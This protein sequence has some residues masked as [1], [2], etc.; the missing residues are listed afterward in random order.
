M[1]EIYNKIITI[2]DDNTDSVLVDIKEKLENQLLVI[3]W[4]EKYG[5]NLNKDTVIKDRDFIRLSDDHYL[6]YFKE[7]REEQENGRGRYISWSDD[8]RQ[9]KDE[10]LLNFSFSTGAYIFDRDYP[11]DIFQDFWNELKTYNPKYIDS[12][13][14]NMYFSLKDAGK[15]LNDYK[16]IYNK[17]V[18]INRE[19]SKKRQIL[20]LQK[21]LDNLNK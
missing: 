6:S 12:A 21:E 9:P 10:W 11:T 14:H 20:K 3:D 19:D 4:N 17:Y 7:A 13:N 2:I 5:L 1:K 16:S 8:D 18:Q 15:V